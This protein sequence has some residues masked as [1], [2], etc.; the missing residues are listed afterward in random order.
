MPRQAIRFGTRGESDVRDR[1]PY[2][3]VM[4]ST[5]DP[6]KHAPPAGH[7]LSGRMLAIV[8]AILVAMVLNNLDRQMLALIK[9]LLDLEFGWSDADYGHFT[10][11]AQLAAALA[12]PVMGWIVDL[13]STRRCFAWGVAVW[14]GFTAAQA[15]AGNAQ[16]L[17][18]IRIGL[19]GAE[20]IGTP[21]ALKM[22]GTLESPRH[23]A[24]SL[25]FFNIAPSLG[26]MMGPILVPFLAWALGWRWAAVIIGS[27]GFIWLAWWLRVS[28]AAP[29]VPAPTT[30]LA[31]PT[32]R[33]LL[34]QAPVWLLIV[35]KA[36]TD[37][38][39]WVFLYWLPAFFA[40][41][42]STVALWASSVTCIYVLAA[43][44]S[45]A[46]AIAAARL[47]RTWSAGVFLLILGCCVAVASALAIAALAAPVVSV[48]ACALAIF[49]HKIVS[50]LV[51][52]TISAEQFR[53]RTGTIAGI[54]AFAGN[55]LAVASLALVGRTLAAGLGHAPV[56]AALAAAYVG[57]GACLILARYGMRR[58]A[59]PVFSAW[60]LRPSR[61]AMKR[62]PEPLP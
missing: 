34:L 39:W 37:Q 51:F 12:L 9:P 33:S 7:P 11:A 31:L 3:R 8:A 41:D 27:L 35:A 10:A 13:V 52:A 36:L 14:S 25:G 5:G 2:S 54:A 24:F 30:N 60:P 42:G 38:L 20:A 21:A 55:L 28:D 59:P 22:F 58:E 45:F 15:L 23:R 62:Q 61:E 19:A 6:A 1:A 47:R 49:G 44:G 18:A 46:G 56:L 40:R 29:P 48:P 26:A 17:L 16:T 50:V 43:L 57:C 32:D 53:A 4:G